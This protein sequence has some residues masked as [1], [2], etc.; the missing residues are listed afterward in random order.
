MIQIFSNSLGVEE[1]TAIRQVFA[2]KW[3]GQGKRCEDFEKELAAYWRAPAGSVLLTNCCTSAIYLALRAIGIRPGDEVIISTIG[4]VACLSAVMELG[5]VPVF[6]DVDQHDLN[7]LPA[8]IERLKTPRTRAVMILHYGG[9]P[10]HVDAILKACGD[11]PLIE[12]SAN[13]I[14]SRY[15]GLACGTLGAAGVWSFDAMKML[16]TGDGGA[17]YVK[18]QYRDRVRCLRYLGLAAGDKTGIDKAA[19]GAGRWWEYELEEPSGR[20]VANDI[21]AAIGLEQLRKL[22]GF[23]ARRR[24]VWEIYQRELAGVGDLVLPPNPRLG[25]TSS[26]YLYWIRSQAGHRDALACHLR[27]R[28]VY[29]TFRYYPLHMVAHSNVHLLRAERVNDTTLNLPL[30]QNLT[31]SDAQQVIDAVRGFYHA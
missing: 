31:D 16:V 25:C 5:A 22:P 24:E 9:N 20:F 12:D 13:S 28:G 1:L 27:D 6:A 2:S 26:Y 19:G 17:L 3:L 14:A 23:I 29:T 11:V 18:E 7:I 21:T 8:E 10:A 4:F 15:H 30:H